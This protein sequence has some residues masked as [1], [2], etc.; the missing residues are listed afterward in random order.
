MSK[1]EIR[2]TKERNNKLNIRF[3]LDTVNN[4]IIFYIDE[5]N[6]YLKQFISSYLWKQHTGTPI[7]LEGIFSNQLKISTEFLDVN[8]SFSLEVILNNGE[9][10]RSPPVIITE[11][12][13]DNF[14]T[15]VEFPGECVATILNVPTLEN[16]SI[17]NF[18]FVYEIG[19]YSILEEDYQFYTNN[20]TIYEVSQNNLSNEFI[21]RFNNIMSFSGESFIF[22]FESNRIIGVSLND[23]FITSNVPTNLRFLSNAEILE[24]N[25]PPVD[26]NGTD[27]LFGQ[28]VEVLSCAIREIPLSNV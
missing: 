22:D 1:F 28:S 18:D 24:R 2:D 10:V 12:I 19:I 9:S 11:D 15:D 4:L 3:K 27:I 23:P 17:G 16:M 20:I 14:N 26:N 21:F 8:S 7:T 6:T 13:L 5:I 25:L